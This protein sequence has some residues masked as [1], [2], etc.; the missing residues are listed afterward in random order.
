M[1]ILEAQNLTH[2]FPDGTVAIEDITLRVN[3]GDFLIIAGANGSV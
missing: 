1:P 3:G 2:I